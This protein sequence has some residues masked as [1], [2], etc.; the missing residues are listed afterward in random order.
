MASW[1]YTL[2]QYNGLTG[3]GD[4]LYPDPPLAPSDPT[5]ALS[6]EDA[7][8]FTIPAYV[9]DLVGPDGGTIIRRWETGVVV[10]REGLAPMVFIVTSVTEERD[11][12]QVDCLGVTAL[13]SGQP[14]RAVRAFNQDDA[15]AIYRH[16]W[17]HHLAY[18]GA[19]FPVTVDAGFKSGV[20]IGYIPLRVNDAKLEEVSVKLDKAEESVDKA[21]AAS[22]KKPADVSLKKALAS[23]KAAR[24]ALRKQREALSAQVE[25]ESKKAEAYAKQMQGKG[26][27]EYVLA[28][29]DNVDLASKASDLAE[30]G[31]FDF[32]TSHAWVG[33]TITSRVHLQKA[34]PAPENPG[35]FQA[36]ENIIEDVPVSMPTEGY[37]TDVWFNGAGEGSARLF[38]ASTHDATST[39]M[40]RWVVKEDS[41]IKSKSILQVKANEQA[42]R[43]RDSVSISEVVCIDHDYAPIGSVRLGDALF[44]LGSGEG[45]NGSID[46]WVKVTAI[47]YSVETDQ[48]RYSVVPI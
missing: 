39:A 28:W 15:A 23:L 2:V 40:T 21:Q 25:A 3:R 38:A 4:I 10:E 37:A 31:G 9:P 1:R 17:S 48:V 32:Y 47:T 34:E 20:P 43:S 16:I 36:G 14:Y 7:F 42:K 6:G 24:D 44:L 30:V 22:D 11:T 12:L 5:V 19:K 35:R 27:E 8:S 45:Y 26:L 41:S 46:R 33:D 29:Y 13:L 18:N